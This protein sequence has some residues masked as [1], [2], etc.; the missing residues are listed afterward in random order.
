MANDRPRGIDHIGI[1]VPDLEVAS[2]FLTDAFGAVALYDN[3]AADDQPQEGPQAEKTLDLAPGTR[4]VHMRMMSLGHGPGIEL[5]EMHGP[6]QQAPVRPSDFGLQHFAVYVDDMAA[7]LARF[8][9][10]GGIVLNSPADQPNLEA[11]PGNVFLYGRTPW[12]SIVELLSTPSREKFDAVSPV[13]R[14]QPPPLA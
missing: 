1:T 11:G 12:G 2:R 8:E 9:K 6:H 5:F 10:A 13:R 7:A 3:I 14:Y 4:V